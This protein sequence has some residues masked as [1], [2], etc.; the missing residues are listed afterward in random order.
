VKIR[1]TGTFCLNSTIFRQDENEPEQTASENQG[2][3]S[4]VIRM[5]NDEAAIIVH[6]DNFELSNEQIAQIR[7]IHERVVLEIA[8]V[9]KG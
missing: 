7:A 1:K 6:V 3:A 5:N 2:E 9:L 8:A 4:V